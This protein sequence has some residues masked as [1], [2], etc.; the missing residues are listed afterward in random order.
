[1]MDE[2]LRALMEQ[3]PDTTL[4]RLE[5]DIWAGVQREELARRTGRVIASCQL[6]V[7]VIALVGGAVAGASTVASANLQNNELGHVGADLAP[8]TLLLGFKP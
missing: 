6:M 1:M 8:S 3:S 7:L 2:D 5:A 4:N